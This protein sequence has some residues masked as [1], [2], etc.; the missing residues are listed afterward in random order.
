MS[1]AKVLIVE[2]DIFIRSTLSSLLEHKGF[3]VVG[4]VETAEEAIIVQRLQKPDVLIID[5]DLGPGPTGIDIAIKL[6]VN[7]PQLGI[8]I[9]TSFSDPRLANTR[10]L[11]LPHGTI[12]LTKSRVHDISVLT[13]SILR[14]KH[15]PLATHK[16]SDTQF[17]QLTETQIEILKLVS[18]GQTTSSIAL[19]RG[20]SEKSVEFVLARTHA[21]LN[22]PRS[23]RLNPRIQ[24]TR[25]FFALSGKKPPG[26]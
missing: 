21:T 3:Q 18:E 5:L 22:L 17:S 4:Q 20:V 12:Y 6:R 9:L 7:N 1:L 24:L 16:R 23:K 10:K 15:S 8:I 14:V 26:E 2:D 11:E 13:T 25:A 19:H